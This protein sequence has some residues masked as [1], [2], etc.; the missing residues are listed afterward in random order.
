M[1]ELI[2]DLNILSQLAEAHRDDF[3]VL[4]YMLELRDDLD[5][6]EIDRYVNE[7]AAP[8]VEAVDCTA[9]A[10]CCRSLDVYVT[11]HDVTRLADGLHTTPESI[12]QTYIEHKTAQQQ[13]EWGKFQQQPCV[14]LKNKLCS[15][16]THRPESCR[17]YPMFTPNFR[18]T[19][20]YMIDGAGQCPI[21]YNVL[22]QLVE[23]VDQL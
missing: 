17:T 23:A 21:I 13:G 8:I 22:D 4:R 3:E 6:A 12:D 7:I 18:W 20:Q 5:D 9:C 16:Y 11:A 1:P 2:T 15:V 14:F 19:M 10:N